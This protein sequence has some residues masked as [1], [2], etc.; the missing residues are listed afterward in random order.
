MTAGES[1]SPWVVTR[2]ADDSPAGPLD[3]RLRNGLI[4][5]FDR[6][7]RGKVS[8]YL[9][10]GVPDDATVRD[11]TR[12]QTGD[13]ESLWDLA[14]L[15]RR[16]PAAER[17]SPVHRACWALEIDNLT[18]PPE[19]G[20]HAHD[21][22]AGLEDAAAPDRED[23]DIEWARSLGSVATDEERWGSLHLAAELWRRCADSWAALGAS[24][25]PAARLAG[26]AARRAQLCEEGITVS[27]LGSAGV[28]Q[29]FPAEIL[30]RSN[31]W[32]FEWHVATDG[33]DGAPE[34]PS[35]GGF[36]GWIGSPR[37]EAS[38]DG[39]PVDLA[40]GVRA[41]FGD[42]GDASLVG[43][44]IPLPSLG[45][46]L[47]AALLGENTQ[48]LLVEADRSG[49]GRVEADL[50]VPT[51][52]V[53]E[54]TLFAV[55]GA[56]SEILSARYPDDPYDREARY[57]E[58]FLCLAERL[59]VGRALAAAGLLVDAG[60]LLSRV[61]TSLRAFGDEITY[62]PVTTTRVDELIAWAA[63][64]VFDARETVNPPAAGPLQ[65]A[66]A[67][68]VPYGTS[69]ISWDRGIGRCRTP[70]P[71]SSVVVELV[72]VIH[73]PGRAR[74]AS[75]VPLDSSTV[76]AS[77]PDGRLVLCAP[78]SCVDGPDRAGREVPC[79]SVRPRHLWLASDDF[80]DA[81]PDDLGDVATGIL[82]DMAVHHH[83]T[84]TGRRVAAQAAQQLARQLDI[85]APTRT[86]PGD[87]AP[88]RRSPE[89]RSRL[90]GA[91]R[92][93]ALLDQRLPAFAV[94]P[95]WRD[96]RDGN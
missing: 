65:F 38:D 23:A 92:R 12:A 22:L 42:E 64:D 94:H 93:L 41:W 87:D 3:L 10:L 68:S 34:E 63:P 30:T 39:R 47:V 81:V 26:E 80:P 24:R 60:P 1:R 52:L 78:G 46:P 5:R 50:P 53:R 91:L 32:I 76:Y 36:E 21:R 25:P 83:G 49:A 37:P 18:V 70:L 2:L 59:R 9:T 27:D 28:G 15:L 33:G 73:G 56:H 17:C 88:G 40:G 31:Q 29:I 90:V 8:G 77:G 13:V 4:L 61:E 75:D 51:E 86:S 74:L 89:E 71:G 57:R 43:A 67:L 58:I 69:V 95:V 85:H 54:L 44:E 20:A 96:L 19:I 35:V 11:V 16:A 79:L 82:I 62:W 55:L 72:L 14:L 48:R 6:A 84:P 66:A 7:V 45:S